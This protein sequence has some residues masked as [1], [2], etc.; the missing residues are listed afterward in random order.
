MMGNEAA[1]TKTSFA[2]SDGSVPKY[3]QAT[4]SYWLGQMNI[5]EM[6]IWDWGRIVVGDLAMKQVN[7]VDETHVVLT[8]DA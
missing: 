4:E 8:S 2:L 5:T 6:S 3:Q 1:I 7:I